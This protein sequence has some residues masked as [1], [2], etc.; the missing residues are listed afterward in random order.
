MDFARLTDKERLTVI[1]YIGN[2]RTF[3]VKTRTLLQPLLG[4]VETDAEISA[5]MRLLQ[6]MTTGVDHVAGERI[7]SRQQ[8]AALFTGQVWHVVE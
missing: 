5:A 7:E 4:S 3:L 8:F 2:H 1:D 6:Q